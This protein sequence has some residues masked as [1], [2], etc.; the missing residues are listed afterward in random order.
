M[1]RWQRRSPPVSG[2]HLK[3]PGCRARASEARLPLR[4]GCG[5]AAAR[6]Q[7]ARPRAS[8]LLI[9]GSPFPPI[10]RPRGGGP[11]LSPVERYGR[12]P[13]SPAA[14]QSRGLAA[15][16][17]ANHPDRP[18]IAPPLGR[19]LSRDWLFWIL[20][21]ASKVCELSGDPAIH[22]LGSSGVPASIL[23]KIPGLAG[24]LPKPSLPPKAS[25]G[26]RLLSQD[27]FRSP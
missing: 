17:L 23:Q 13:A 19:S 27:F 8:L 10:T 21:H 3:A 16:L 25:N 7:A 4:L 18:A 26:Y 20:C 12:S 22:S 2:P 9:P 24:T 6:A 14:W 5:D 15:R 1:P 11:P